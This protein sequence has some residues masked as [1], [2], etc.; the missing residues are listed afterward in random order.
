MSI[1]T[2]ESGSDV[3]RSLVGIDRDA[4]RGALSARWKLIFYR[5]AELEQVYA[6]C[7]AGNGHE[8]YRTLAENWQYSF[9]QTHEIIMI[10]RIS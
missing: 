8:E 3:F 1:G 5:I 6:W 9:A 10:E 4:K 2:F 7:R